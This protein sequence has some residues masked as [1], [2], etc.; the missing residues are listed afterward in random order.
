[1]DANGLVAVDD[2]QACVALAVDDMFRLKMVDA[3]LGMLSEQDDPRA[4]DAI[5]HYQAQ[6]EELVKRIQASNPPP[7]VVQANVATLGSIG[8]NHGPR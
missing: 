6:R 4:P 1:M 7:V 3:F 2:T 5:A 8:G